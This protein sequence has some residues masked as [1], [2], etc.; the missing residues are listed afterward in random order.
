MSES[1]AEEKETAPSSAPEETGEVKP[2]QEDTSSAADESSKQEETQEKSSSEPADGDKD[3]VEAKSEAPPE[4]VAAA[5]PVKQKSKYR[6]DWYQTERDV[7]VNVMIK[8]LK[9]ENVEVDIKEKF[10]SRCIETMQR[11]YWMLHLI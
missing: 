11:G 2:E 10:V 1:T 9:K 6:Y 5:Q 7:C 3:A 4:P 8:R